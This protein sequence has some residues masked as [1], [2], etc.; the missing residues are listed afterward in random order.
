MRLHSCARRNDEVEWRSPGMSAGPMRISIDRQASPSAGLRSSV[1]TSRSI[2]LGSCSARSRTSDRCA[3]SLH[4][5]DACANAHSVARPTTSGSTPVT[6]CAIASSSSC[7]R[8][9]AVVSRRCA[10]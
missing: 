5:L 7:G 1:R 8:S 6:C 4:R 10:G 9:S 2:A 3:G